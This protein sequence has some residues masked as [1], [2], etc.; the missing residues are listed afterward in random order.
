MLSYQFIEEGGDGEGPRRHANLAELVP[1]GD[2]LTLLQHLEASM[3][4]LDASD[5]RNQ[6]AELQAEHVRER[7]AAL[8]MR[9]ERRRA[10][11]AGR[12]D[13]QTR[14]DDLEEIVAVGSVEELYELSG[15]RLSDLHKENADEV[16]I[17]SKQGKGTLKRI[18]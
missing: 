3:I 15:V 5:N 12:G 17:P 2:L 13:Q 11:A 18:D 4:W 6:Q 8:Q 7:R 1:L 10:K 9:L 16:T 14:S